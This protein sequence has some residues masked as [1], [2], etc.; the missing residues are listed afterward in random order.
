MANSLGAGALNRKVTIVTQSSAHDSYGQPIEAWTPVLNHIWAG[1]S[2]PTG[3]QIYAAKGFV[4]VLSH[5]ITIRYTRTPILPNMHVIYGTRKFIVNAIMNRD[6]ANVELQ[7]L[8]L[9][10]V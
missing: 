2:S 7:L 9:E 10:L 6:E 1:I 5:V 4:E 3:K 8:C